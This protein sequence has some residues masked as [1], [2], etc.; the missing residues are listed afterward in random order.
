MKINYK[1]YSMKEMNGLLE[2]L[3]KKEDS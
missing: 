3:D 1:E 2:N